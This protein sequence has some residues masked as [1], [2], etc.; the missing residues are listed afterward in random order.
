[1]ALGAQGQLQ[2]ALATLEQSL[3]IFAELR[4]RDPLY[5]DLPALM[6]QFL[7][8]K[9]D[10]L[11]RLGNIADAQK[12]YQKALPNFEEV[13]KAAP[14]PKTRCDRG[15]AYAK[16][17]HVLVVMKDFDGARDHF[18]KA[19]EFTESL[20]SQSPVNPLSLYVL[21]DAY[22]GLGDLEA[23]QAAQIKDSSERIAHWKNAVS[24]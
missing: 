5:Q 8:W 16:L 4:A 14:T 19:L 6:G 7:I 9:G 11:S 21:A 15:T 2:E 1:M 17:G 24:W 23:S 10:V 12:S 18:Q 3:A 20:A 13:A 22:S